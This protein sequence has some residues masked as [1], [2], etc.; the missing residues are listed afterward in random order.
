MNTMLLNSG[1]LGFQEVQ[2][3]SDADKQVIL[4]MQTLMVLHWTQ[5]RASVP[6]PIFS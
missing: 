3:G 4:T 5:D 1:C 2:K 6:D